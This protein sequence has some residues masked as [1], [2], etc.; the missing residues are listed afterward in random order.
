VQ[1]LGDSIAAGA[2]AKGYDVLGTRTPATGAGIVSIR[3]P[4]QDARLAVHSLKSKGFIAAPRQGWI[5]LSPHFYISPDDIER[6]L[7]A[8]Q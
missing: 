5:R 4:G 7:N 3:K 8:L 6:L 2:A 1:A